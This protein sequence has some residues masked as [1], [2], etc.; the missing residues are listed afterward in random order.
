[1]TTG[2]LGNYNPILNGFREDNVTDSDWLNGWMDVVEG[3]S[4]G[5]QRDNIDALFHL[6]CVSGAYGSNWESV[7]L[8]S[9][10]AMGR[11]VLRINTDDSNRMRLYSYN[12]VLAL[13]QPSQYGEK[14]ITTTI[15]EITGT[16]AGTAIDYTETE[17]RAKHTM[18]I[19]GNDNGGTFNSCEVNFE[20]S[21]DGTNY[22]IQFTLTLSAAG[23]ET[24]D[25]EVPAVKVRYNVISISVS[26]DADLD[27][28]IT[29]I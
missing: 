16:G 17:A 18:Q 27:I 15:E 9:S 5:Y 24:F 19:T 7:S 28:A 8:P 26:G 22:D 11:S 20:V 14:S 2:G 23:G 12:S 25:I 1:M 10:P 3:K 29:S 13:W 21:M 4:D 6:F